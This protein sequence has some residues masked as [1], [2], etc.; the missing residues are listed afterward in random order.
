ML[1]SCDCGD[2]NCPGISEK[3]KALNVYKNLDSIVFENDFGKRIVFYKQ[4]F[5]ET[6]AQNIKCD[7][8]KYTIPQK[9][10]CKPCPQKRTYYWAKTYDTLWTYYDTIYKQKDVYDNFSYLIK[11]DDRG[12]TTYE[13]LSIG[14]LNSHS[15]FNIQNDSSL[16]NT[17]DSFYTSITIKNKLFSNVYMNI[18]DTFTH[19]QSRRFYK[20]FIWKIYFNKANGLIAFYDGKTKS[21]FYKID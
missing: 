2:V 17:S 16:Q 14:L 20:T 21:H 19:Y 15:N 10:D 5:D 18:N 8:E 3:N 11:E 13:N 12:G 9:C 7:Y 6:L 1:M 4:A